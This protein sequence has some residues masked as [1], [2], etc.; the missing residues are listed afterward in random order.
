[1]SGQIIEVE[2]EA[3][4][5]KYRWRMDISTPWRRIARIRL[6]P[7]WAGFLL[8]NYLPAQSF[9]QSIYRDTIPS[10]YGGSVGK[11]MWEHDDTDIAWPGGALTDRDAVDQ[12]NHSGKVYLDAQYFYAIL[13]N[14]ISV[15]Y[16]IV[17]RGTML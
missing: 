14:S 6:V 8:S 12:T 7:R 13:H 17:G 9:S 16:I 10:R 2:Y 1:M 11:K 3:E 5:I 15:T 4:K